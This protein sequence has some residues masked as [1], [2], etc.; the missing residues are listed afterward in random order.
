MKKSE[1][2]VKITEENRLE[3]LSIL[4]MFEEPVFWDSREGMK[5]GDRKY[6]YIHFN[7][8]YWVR[9][10]G[11][12]EEKKV[13]PQK[14]KE[15]LADEHG[16]K[17]K[18]VELPKDFTQVKCSPLTEETAQELIKVIRGDY[19]IAR[20]LHS[21]KF[22]EY[23]G[24]PSVT[25]KGVDIGVG[26]DFRSVDCFSFK[27]GVV[28]REVEFKKDVLKKS[29]WQK[30]KSYPEYL[31]YFD[32][33]NKKRYGFNLNG[34]WVEDFDVN[35]FNDN[36]HIATTKEV[37]EALTKEAIKRGLVKKAK[38]IS[39]DGIDYGYTMDN[40]E[41]TLCEEGFGFHCSSSTITQL[42]YK[43]K[44]AIPTEEEYKDGDIVIATIGEDEYIIK[45]KGYLKEQRKIE[46]HGFMLMDSRTPEIIPGGWF[47]SIKRHA[48]PEEV[49]RFNKLDDPL[50]DIKKG[51]NEGKVVEVLDGDVWRVLKKTTWS[52]DSQYR[53]QPQPKIGDVC[54][55][56]DDD[57]SDF[58][59]GKINSIDDEANFKYLTADIISKP[60]FFK[61]ATPLTQQQVIDLLFK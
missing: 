29:S 47:E 13:T 39:P 54:K 50:Y 59:I 12:I 14:L 34:L 52:T 15:I 53:I 43:G 16:V 31:I 23:Y 26:S 40:D 49:D 3:I 1:I 6:S 46:A 22:N 8:E 42:M 20:K 5:K 10:T 7:G 56:W 60:H 19:S 24:D 25:V 35:C 32:F 4:D 27:D 2:T 9:S 45:F 55:F 37:T 17:G 11:G 48:T 51:Y 30:D 36:N 28:D 33:E 21:I 58:V 41:Y 18:N 61:N 57:E 38:F 44:W